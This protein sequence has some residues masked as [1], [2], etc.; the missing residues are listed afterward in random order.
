MSDVFQPRSEPAKS[1]YRALVAEMAHR[2]GRTVE[3][4][5]NAERA[6]IHGEAKRQ[7]KALGLREPTDKEVRMAETSAMGHSDYCLKYALHV[8]QAMRSK[9]EVTFS[10]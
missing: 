6:A 10:G 7:A 2:K 8:A 1:L 9:A 4:F 3:E 5:V